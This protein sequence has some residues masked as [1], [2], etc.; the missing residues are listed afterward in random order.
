MSYS[1]TLAGYTATPRGCS[2][3]ITEVSSYQGDPPGMSLWVPLPY[4]HLNTPH[5]SS[6]NPVL[7]LCKEGL[8]ASACI[9]IRWQDGTPESGLGL[10]TWISNTSPAEADA[11]T[12]PGDCSSHWDAVSHPPSYC[13]T[14]STRGCC[15]ILRRLSAF[16]HGESSTQQTEARPS[17]STSS[18]SGH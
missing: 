15:L 13:G 8:Q 17:G 2:L 14:Y 11:E 16:L 1:V 4:S 10:R 12:A 5:L 18:H 7:R 6:F 3:V 9:R